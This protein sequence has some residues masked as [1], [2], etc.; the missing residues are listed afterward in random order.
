LVR[1]DVTNIVSVQAVQKH[2]VITMVSGRRHSVRL[3]LAEVLAYLSSADFVQCHR[4]W[5][6]SLRHIEHVEL[7]ANLVRLTDGTDALLGRAYRQN[8]QQCLRIIG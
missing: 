7:S 1:L 3:T 5:I 6:V 4:A 8:I 2:A